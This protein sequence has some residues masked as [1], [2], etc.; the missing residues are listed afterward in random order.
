MSSSPGFGTTTGGFASPVSV[1]VVTVVVPKIEDKITS[2]SV[3]VVA[4][5]VVVT[6]TGGSATAVSFTDCRLA[7]CP[8]K[9]GPRCGIRNGAGSFWS[10]LAV[11][12]DSDDNSGKA[13]TNNLRGPFI[14]TSRDLRRYASV[15]QS[16]VELMYD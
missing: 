6:T 7:S 16:V 11:T 10:G 5:V 12:N 4:A 14:A 15:Y 1:V 9:N 2:K 8:G 3:V 13:K